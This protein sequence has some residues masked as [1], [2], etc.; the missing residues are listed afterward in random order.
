MSLH[1]VST[2]SELSTKINEWRS[3]G[4]KIGFVPTMGALHDG[5]L[6][7]VR[8]A[9]QHADRIVVSIFVNP[10]Q[11]APNEDFAAYPRNV[12]ADT[13]KL[14]DA[15]AHL[16]YVP[17]QSEIYPVVAASDVKAGKVAQGLEADIRP[18]HFD[19][20]VTVVSKLFKQVRPDVAIFGEKD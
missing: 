12:D 5:H 10:T 8:I 2:A 15:G 9:R 20:V 19:G 1:K 13:A 17:S 11:F 18:T 14:K 16:V 6:S 7:L 4:L 3:E